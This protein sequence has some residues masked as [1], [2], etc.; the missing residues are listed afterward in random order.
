VF[1]A[2]S[3]MKDGRPLVILGM[4]GVNVTR[5]IAHEPVTVDVGALG[6]GMPELQVVIMYGKTEAVIVDQLRE[7][8]LI[9]P[10]TEERHA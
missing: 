3:R 5:M 1:K 6:D 9:G 8:G 7:A 2:T 4:S 10:D